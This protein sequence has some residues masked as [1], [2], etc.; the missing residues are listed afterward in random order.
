MNP[1]AVI[2]FTPFDARFSR[3]VYRHELWNRNEKEAV[4]AEY[5][6]VRSLAGNDDEHPDATQQ[7]LN[8]F[9]ERERQYKAS[10]ITPEAFRRHELALYAGLRGNSVAILVA[11]LVE[12]VGAMDFDNF[13]LADDAQERSKPMT[14]YQFSAN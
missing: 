1:D 10:M 13:S 14:R 7:I 4:I 11:M 5:L 8:A 3:W 9:K 2:T 6:A 12:R